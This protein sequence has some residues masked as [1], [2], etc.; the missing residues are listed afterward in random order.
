M[1]TVIQFT[2]AQL[3]VLAGAIITISTAC[4]V[5]VNLISKLKEPEKK[6]DERIGHCEERLNKM[7][8]VIEKFQGYFS[9]D[10]RRFKEIEE[11]NKITQTALLALLKHSLNG[12]DTKAL[13]EAEKSLEEYLI[14]K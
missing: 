9:N 12:N 6:Q 4:G 11:G 8:A 10:D 5:I 2:P 14:N 7:D 1:D 13:R 3:I